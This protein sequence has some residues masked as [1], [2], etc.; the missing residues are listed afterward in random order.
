MPRGSVMKQR[1]GKLSGSF[2]AQLQQFAEQ[3]KAKMDAIFQ[4]V[5]I[6][7]GE[8]IIRLSPVDTGLFKGNWQMTVDTPASGHIENFDKEGSETIAKLVASASRLEAGQVAWIVNNLPYAI[9]LEFGHSQQAPAGVV[10]VTLARF[11]EIVAAAV[12]ANR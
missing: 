11:Q 7:I 2:S 3:T 5:V 4:D 6:E 1:Y 8:S 9:P 12:Q 10:R